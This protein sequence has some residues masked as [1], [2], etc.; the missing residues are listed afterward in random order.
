[1]KLEIITTPSGAELTSIKFQGKEYLHQGENVLDKEGKVYWKRR[2]PILFPIVG[3]LKNNA[4]TIQGKR[5]EMSQHG[6]ARDMKFDIINISEREHTYMLRYNEETLKMYPFKFELY[7]SYLV[8]NDKLTVK[9]IVKNLDDKSMFFGIG[10]HPAFA[11]DLRENKY[12]FEFD[13]IEENERFYQLDN[14]LI[15]Y[16]D[17]Y[18]NKSLLSNNKCIN[19]QKDTFTHDAI[20]MSDLESQKV[21]LIENERTKLEVDFTG[22][23]YL[24]FWS[25]KNAPF[26]CIEPWYTTADYTDSDQVFENKKDNIKLEI[27]EQFEC[28]YSIKFEE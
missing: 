26:V 27:G 28:E 21:R 10:G 1:M 8:D 19:I 6:F 7:V 5:Y 15:S 23:K 17:N 25:K 18:I 24:A 13:K 22:F 9:Y 12:R 2:A 14:G 16:K 20:I 3:S 11:I 4:T